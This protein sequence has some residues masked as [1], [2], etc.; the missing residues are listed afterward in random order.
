M[1]GAL[2]EDETRTRGSSPAKKTGERKFVGRGQEKV[3]GRTKTA[4]KRVFCKAHLV[5]RSATE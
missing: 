2:S 4:E 1:R 3:A 5:E